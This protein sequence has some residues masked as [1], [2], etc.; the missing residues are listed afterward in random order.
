[1]FSQLRTSTTALVLLVAMVMVA[2][3]SAT[4][5][6]ANFPGSCCTGMRGNVDGVGIVELADLSALISYLTGG[7]YVP[8][9]LDRANV[10]GQG[11]VDLAD[12]STLVA[13]L[14]GLPAVPAQCP[15][16]TSFM[17]DTLRVAALQTVKQA[18]SSFAHLPVDSFN[19]LMLTYL[20]SRPEFVDAGIS[21]SAGNV[22]ARFPDGVLLFV[23]NSFGNSRDTLPGDPLPPDTIGTTESTRHEPRLAEARRA[24]NKTALGSGDD[25]PKS[26]GYRLIAPLGSAYPAVATTKSRLKSWLNSAHYIEQSPLAS[27]YEMRRVG[28]DGLF[29]YFG[30]GGAGKTI[31]IVEGE[32]EYGIWTSSSAEVIDSI[33]LFAED[34]V[35]KRL[36]YCLAPNGFDTLTNQVIPA[37]RIGITSKFISYYWQ[38]FAQ[39]ALVIIN[40][41]GSDSVPAFRN[42]IQAK[43]GPTYFGWSVSVSSKGACLSTEYLV[44]RLLGANKA[45]PR[46]NP[47]QRP[48][49]ASDVYAD[50]QAQGFHIRPGGDS[51]HSTTS[52]FR[53]HPGASNFGLLAPTI[54]FMAVEEPSD[55]LIVNGVFGAD[56][57]PDGRVRVNG[58]NLTVQNWTVNEIR[59]DLPRFGAGSE[60]PVTVEVAADFGGLGTLTFRKSN[61]VN[62]SSWRIPFHYDHIEGDQTITVD[63]ELHVRADIHSHREAPHEAPIEP[64]AVPFDHA[65]DSE[66]S[67]A[68]GG[69]GQLACYTQSWAGSGILPVPEN[70]QG[71]NTLYANGSID[72]KG[73]NV[74]ILLGALFTEG[75]NVNTCGVLP[76]P[77][78]CTDGEMG[79]SFDL[80][81]YESFFPTPF[82]TMYLNSNF[83]LLQGERVPTGMYPVQTYGLFQGTP[84]VKLNWPTVVP[85]FAPDQEAAQ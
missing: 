8:P 31:S 43:G 28:G 84:T 9:C 80:G 39:N 5:E 4:P 38:P 76:C 69:S 54:S 47:K 30:H 45:Y 34:F 15:S 56:P 68:I 75:T 36:C 67:F 71:T 21:E 40:A 1:M 33:R 29:C 6:A 57:G 50:M 12:L 51:V 60:G 62:L 66:G 17:S 72:A 32:L 2:S 65:L 24:P 23:T 85:G 49:P 18:F 26:V 42:A 14:I 10:N 53:Y 46:E 58:T 63:M 37:A 7:G 3:A 59:C 41:C 52:T 20:Q 27:V 70:T 16:D 79:W 48:F 22:W 77:T 83:D 19:N 55:V 74:T 25:L 82:F 64:D 11:V 35:T 81:L 44:D 78:G 73:K 13:Y 61:E